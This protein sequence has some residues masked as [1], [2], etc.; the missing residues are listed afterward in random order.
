MAIITER[1]LQ[2]RCIGLMLEFTW[3]TS[4]WKGMDFGAD[5]SPRSIDEAKFLTPLRYQLAIKRQPISIEG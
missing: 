2:D 3:F 1:R 5:A 4:F